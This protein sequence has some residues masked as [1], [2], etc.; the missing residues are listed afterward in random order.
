MTTSNSIKV[1]ARRRIRVCMFPIVFISSFVVTD[2]RIGSSG[3]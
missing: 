2:Y 3:N 1:N